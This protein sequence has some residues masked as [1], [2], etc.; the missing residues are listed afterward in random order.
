MSSVASILTGT[1]AVV[2]PGLYVGG[3]GG[4]GVTSLNALTGVVSLAS[5]GGTIVVG[6]AGSIIDLDV[7]PALEVTSLTASGA[8]AGLSGAFSSSLEVGSPLVNVL[9][10]IN[11]YADDQQ[12]GA[13]PSTPAGGV[14]L[15]PA[16][17][18]TYTIPTAGLY[19]FEYLFAAQL[20]ATPNPLVVGSGDCLQIEGTFDGTFLPLPFGTVTDAETN[21]VSSTAS[22]ILKCTAGQV[23]SSQLAIINSSAT[24]RLGV[25]GVVECAVMKL[26]A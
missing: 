16:V 19:Y 17:A 21:F 25:N 18:L 5:N 2:N 1:P 23:I 26:C 3:G 13:I 9:P 8:V 22:V 14:T 24:M 4:G 11:D 10:S 20:D 7:N 6:G 15:L 12:I